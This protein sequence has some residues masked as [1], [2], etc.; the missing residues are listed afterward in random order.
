M[1]NL[2]NEDAILNIRSIRTLS[3]NFLLFSKD[4]VLSN[5]RDLCD[6]LN[7][8]RKQ[9]M[10]ENLEEEYVLV[11]VFNLYINKIIAMKD[12]MIPSMP[13]CLLTA[14]LQPYCSSV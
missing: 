9:K 11:D 10:L 6:D 12:I 8:I 13:L 14:S 1:I 7:E 4:I 3:N 5:S 2:F